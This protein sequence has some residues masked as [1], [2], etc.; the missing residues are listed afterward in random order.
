[1]LNLLV[2]SPNHRITG[3]HSFSSESPFSHSCFAHF[4]VRIAH[5]PRSLEMTVFHSFSGQKHHCHTFFRSFSSQNHPF[6][7]FFLSLRVRIAH[8]PHFPRNDCLSLILLSESPFSHSFFHSF[9]CP[10]RSFHQT[11]FS[12]IFISESPF[13]HPFCRHCRVWIAHFSIFLEMTVFH[14]F[15]CQNHHSR[16]FFQSFSCLNRSFAHFPRHDCL[17][18][19]S[20]PNRHS[21]TLFFTLWS[22]LSHTP[23]LRCASICSRDQKDSLEPGDGVHSPPGGEVVEEQLSP[24]CLRLQRCDAGW[25]AHPVQW[26][27]ENLD[28]FHAKF[29]DS[30]PERHYYSNEVIVRGPG[31]EEV[32]FRSWWQQARLTNQ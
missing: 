21:C 17:P 32:L 26:L 24:D 31:A 8:F 3:L 25:C 23:L 18:L 13:S 16:T 19:I 30:D 10:N 12:L 4:P 29:L 5:L 27:E 6:S 9:S 11:F 15:S 20:S 2:S 1:M 14:S 22:L 7:H 28:I